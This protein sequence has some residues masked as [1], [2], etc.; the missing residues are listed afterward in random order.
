MDTLKNASD[1]PIRLPGGGMLL[2]GR[3]CAVDK[4]TVLLLKASPFIAAHIAAGRL[5]LATKPEAVV[6]A[7]APAKTRKSAAAE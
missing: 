4:R 1:A 2:P 5:V 6:P 3:T 7:E